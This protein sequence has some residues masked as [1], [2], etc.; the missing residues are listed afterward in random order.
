MTAPHK[1]GFFPGPVAYGN[2]PR[3]YPGSPPNI[4]LRRPSRRA[5]ATSTRRALPELTVRL[6]A[7]DHLLTVGV[8]G[9]VDDGLGRNHL[10]II[11]EAEMAETFGDGVQPRRLRLVPERVVRVGSVD[12]LGQENDGRVAVQLVLLRQRVEGALFAMVAELNPLHVERGCAFALGHLQYLVLRD[13]QKLSL[14]VDEFADEPRTGHSV[15]L[16]SL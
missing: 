5:I 16:Y 12:D 9:V 13:E 14:R 8:Q 3:A 11:L 2:T 7:A 15:H 1:R 4:V 10:Q 6:A